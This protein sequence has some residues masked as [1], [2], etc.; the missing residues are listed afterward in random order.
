MSAKHGKRMSTVLLTKISVALVLIV[1]LSI[2][3]IATVIAH[4]VTANVIDGDKTYSFGME[5]ADI[6]DIIATA[7]TQGMEPIGELDVYEIV[8]NT[9]TVNVRRGVSVTVN[10]AGSVT[11]FVSYKDETVEKALLQNGIILK[12]K[13][14]VTPA[15]ESMLEEDTNI[16]IRR[17]CTVIVSADGK[18]HQ[19]SLTGGTVEEAISEAGIAVGADDSVNYQS[20][21]PLFDNMKI[22]VSRV[23]TVKITVDG[24][25]KEHKISAATVSEALKKVGVV[26][27]ADDKLSH[28]SNTKLTDNMEIVIK[29]VIKKEVTKTEGIPFETVYETDSSMY[30]DESKV[31]TEGILGEK[32]VKCSEIYVDEVFEKSEILS[33]TVIKEPVNEVIV[34]GTKEYEEKENT[35]SN[36]SSSGGGSTGTGNGSTFVDTSGNVVSYSGVLQGTATAYCDD[37]LTAIGDPCG[38][39]YVA[40]N[41]NV[42]PYGTRL[43][44]C[45]P[46]G[47]YTYGYAVASDTGGALMSGAALVDIWLPS[48]SDC[49][50]FGRRTMNV[51]ILG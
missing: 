50:S 51:Y 9:T 44:I 5:S 18:N 13:D 11:N 35:S 6:E 34:K 8:G 26:V 49:Y 42:I 38:Y 27:S 4:P 1:A 29:R 16:D 20:A 24:E 41:P 33:E 43:Y 47:S 30:I 21:E 17:F 37:G 28:K 2:S 23:V 40:V 12:D 7:E 31:K 45:S 36:G 19:V 25:T 46:D 3:S 32:E 39:G 48:E 22:N 14:V 15:R 10:E